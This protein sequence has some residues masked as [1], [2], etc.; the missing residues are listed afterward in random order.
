[1]PVGSLIEARIKSILSTKNTSNKLSK[2]KILSK[3]K[4]KNKTNRKAETKHKNK[5][6]TENIK[7]NKTNKKSLEEYNI[8]CLICWKFSL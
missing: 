6:N 8:S 3:T 7:T 2:T 1:M 5:T 4:P